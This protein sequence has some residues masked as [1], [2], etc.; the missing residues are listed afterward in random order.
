M[1]RLGTVRADTYN[2]LGSLQ[3]WGLHWKKADPIIRAIKHPDDYGI[4]SKL[5]E[6]TVNDVVK[7]INA[8]QEAAKVYL[9]RAIYNKYPLTKLE[10]DRAEWIKSDEAK[11]LLLSKEDLKAES[12]SRFPSSETEQ[13][14]IRL[15]ELLLCCPTSDPWL[16]RQFRK[17][18]IR[19]HSQ[20]RNQIVYQSSGYSC[21]RVNRHL[22]LLEIA[23]LKRGNRI[24]LYVKSNR[25]IKGQIRLIAKE[26]N[27][28]V[29]NL[30]GTKEIIEKPKKYQKTI[31][32]DKGYT[33]A[34][35][36]SNGTTVGKG[37]GK[38]LTEKTERINQKNQ[39][40]QKLFALSLK[41][42]ISNP[43]KAERIKENNLG[44]RRENQ[45]LNSA[46]KEVQNLIRKDLRK[47]LSVPTLIYAE[48]LSFPIKSKKQ[49]K[50]INRRLNSW[51]KGEL[52]QSLETIALQT[53]SKIELVNPAYTSQTDPDNGT[54]LGVRS[55]DCFTSFT[56]VVYWADHG[57]A[58]NI[59]TRGQDREITRYMKSEKVLEVLLRRTVRFL[60]S[61]GYSVEYALSQGWLQPKFKEVALRIESEETPTGVVGTSRKKR[62]RVTKT[63]YPEVKQLTIWD[64]SPYSDSNTTQR[65]SHF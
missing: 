31:G 17:Q 39:K 13:E 25:I 44:R 35:V 18:Y 64:I 49:S 60:S 41:N 45:R 42:Q 57:A 26:G 50:R 32:V 6:W 51:M 33:E 16:H 61:F 56:G 43:K 38:L 14:R 24:Q 10:K 2:K 65:K 62:K 30:V 58:K 52:Q 19:G 40:R 5:F 55:G 11:S 20:L 36:T 21:Q 23:G 7:C 4:P 28:E 22:V 54:L 9:I 34:F 53:G 48:D 46:Q 47:V 1:A 27:F 8:S 29:H 59:L 12:L 63:H 37:L 3:G 15:L